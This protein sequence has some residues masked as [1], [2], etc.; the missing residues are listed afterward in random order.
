MKGKLYANNQAKKGIVTE[1]IKCLKDKDFLKDLVVNAVHAVPIDYTKY[2]LKYNTEKYDSIRKK[3]SN[4]D[5]NDSLGY[6]TSKK[7]SSDNDLPI[8]SNNPQIT[9][10]KGVSNSQKTISTMGNSNGS[11]NIKQS[12]IKNEK[13]DLKISSVFK[14]EIEN[15][16][17]D[18]IDLNFQVKEDGVDVLDLN[19]LNYLKENDYIYDN[20]IKIIQF[21]AE[22]AQAK[23]Y[24]GLIEEIE[25]YVAIKRYTLPKYDKDIIEKITK[26]NEIL[27]NLENDFI[28]KYFDI[29]YTCEG[30][31]ECVS[32]FI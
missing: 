6:N 14:A 12:S 30:D 4:E 20:S 5:L 31:S 24:L 27:K 2:R 22:G 3:I 23:V 16:N 9:N 11:D 29:D 32:L 17:L 8:I 7:N 15:F 25:K 28:I 1:K 26:E 19:K 18:E 21:I 10:I 13:S